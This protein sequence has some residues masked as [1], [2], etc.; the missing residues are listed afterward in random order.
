MACNRD[1][2]AVP[3][4]PDDFP[5]VNEV[6]KGCIPVHLRI[7]GGIATKATSANAKED[8]IINALLT[9][10]GLDSDNKEVFVDK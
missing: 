6:T 8:E 10:T 5:A 7:S 2:L 3:N 9:V 4:Q 1:N